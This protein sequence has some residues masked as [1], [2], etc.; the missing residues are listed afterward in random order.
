MG[1][2]EECTTTI[3]G[4]LGQSGGDG[5]EK[6]ALLAGPPGKNGGLSYPKC[7]LACRPAN[8]KRSVGGQRRRWNDLVRSDLQKCNMLADWRE[9]AQE[10]AAWRGV[11][12]MMT[13]KLNGQLEAA[14]KERK[15]ERKVKREEGIQLPSIELRCEE[16][17]CMFVGQ[18]KAGLVNHTR[19]R[20]GRKAQLQNKCAFCDKSFHKQGI[21]MH[22]RH[23]QMNPD[24]R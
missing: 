15:D 7:L 14:E 1:Q 8:G 10:R 2:D 12:K 9:L 22:M 17:G 5:Y 6:K 23:C 24:R 18:T 3:S 20:H 16:P 13:A 11:V 4:W 21:T 19:Q